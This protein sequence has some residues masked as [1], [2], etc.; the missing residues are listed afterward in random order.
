MGVFVTYAMFTEISG[1]T[2]WNPSAAAALSL[3][4]QSRSNDGS[5]SQVFGY[6]AGPGYVNRK[7]ELCPELR[8][9]VIIRVTDAAG[10]RFEA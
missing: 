5:R 6:S 7:R 10:R 3:G 8:V 9:R 4:A 2:C 1:K